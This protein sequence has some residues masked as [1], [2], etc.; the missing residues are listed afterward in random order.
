M[1][2]FALANRAGS[3][4]ALVLFGTLFLVLVWG[5]VREMRTRSAMSAGA[6]FVFGTLGFGALIV[7]LYASSLNGF[8][9][10]HVA[11]DEVKLR[12]LFPQLSTT[13]PIATV[14]QVSA[15]PSYKSLWRLRIQ[16]NSGRV[17][18]STRSNRNAVNATTERLRALTQVA[19]QR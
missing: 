4:T 9:E 12:Y 19:R 1:H 16:V 11:D 6:G 8:Y 18:E 3:A 5:V 10:V 2:D 14:A 15:V 17:F 7:L 13:I